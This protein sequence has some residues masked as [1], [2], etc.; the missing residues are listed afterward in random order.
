MLA[1]ATVDIEDDNAQSKHLRK[2][3]FLPLLES[4]LGVEMVVGPPK[5]LIPVMQEKPTPHTI[6]GCV[7]ASILKRTLKTL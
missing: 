3:P 4:I 7:R 6:E 1:H 2:T 5:D